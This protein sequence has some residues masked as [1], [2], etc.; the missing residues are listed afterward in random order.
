LEFVGSESSAEHSSSIGANECSTETS[1]LD[2]LTL[3]QSSSTSHTASFPKATQARKEDPMA[4]ENTR[5][6]CDKNERK[7]L[8]VA[9]KRRSNNSRRLM[10]K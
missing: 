8:S 10:T 5:I 2:I 1:V 7:D 4:D 3:T 6:A 9:D